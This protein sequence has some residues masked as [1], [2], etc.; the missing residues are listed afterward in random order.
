VNGYGKEWQADLP[1][2]DEMYQITAYAVSDAVT[3]HPKYRSNP[4]AYRRAAVQWYTDK[5][6]EGASH[7]AAFKFVT[8]VAAKHAA[9][10]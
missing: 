9:A 8:D 6:A 3:K 5:R 2:P 10:A 1:T 4:L 7:E